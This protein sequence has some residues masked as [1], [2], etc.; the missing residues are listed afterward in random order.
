MRKPIILPLLPLLL[1]GI[2]TVT[3][4]AATPKGP[5]KLVAIDV[6]K[7]GHLDPAEFEAATAAGV[8]IPFD[9][10]DRAPKDGKISKKE[11]SVLM[12]E[13]CE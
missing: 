9:K 4:N 1:L 10:L 3:A 8:V 13:D 11:Y 5:P 12:D 2:G 6:N 7:D